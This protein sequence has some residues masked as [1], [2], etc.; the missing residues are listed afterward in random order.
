M[1]G[2]TEIL[3]HSPSALQALGEALA[4]LFGPI[5][6]STLGNM[7]RTVA[8]PQPPWMPS[9]VSALRG[10]YP[11]SSYSLPTCTLSLIDTLLKGYRNMVIYTSLTR[12]V[13]AGKSPALLVIQGLP[14]VALTG[15]RRSAGII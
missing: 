8:G 3:L 5:N 4:L 6:P 9:Q 11:L 1:A 12:A 2:I 7:T 13:V 14:L 10:W 15:R